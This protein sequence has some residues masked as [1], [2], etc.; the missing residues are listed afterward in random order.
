MVEMKFLKR[1]QQ[2]IERYGMIAIGDTVIVG[3]SGGPD[4]M[5]LLFV[6]HEMQDDY[7]LSLWASHYNHK[8]RGK[9]SD[10]EAEFVKYQA[11]RIGVRQTVDG[12]GGKF[13]VSR[14]WFLVGTD[15][16]TLPVASN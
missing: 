8:L 10:R 12:H 14:F 6:L 3:V 5:A 2:T 1:I 13:L 9:E 7:Q 16:C 11:E 4:S 15:S